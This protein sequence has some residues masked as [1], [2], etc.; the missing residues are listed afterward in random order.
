M[1][2]R[3]WTLE[4]TFINIIRLSLVEED[5]CGLLRKA[6]VYLVTISEFLVN[7]FR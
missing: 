7:S 3:K 5:F 1:D 2:K 6:E 4:G